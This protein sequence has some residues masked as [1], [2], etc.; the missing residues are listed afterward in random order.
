MN[1]T[2]LGVLVEDM[3]HPSLLSFNKSNEKGGKGIQAGTTATVKAGTRDTQSECVVTLGT[4][5]TLIS[6]QSRA[7]SLV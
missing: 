3:P 2:C 6:C 5:I 7:K 4:W 1:L